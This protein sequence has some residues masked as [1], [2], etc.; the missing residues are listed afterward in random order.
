MEKENKKVL[1]AYSGGLDTS[2][3]LKWLLEKGYEVICFM[4]DVGQDEDFQQARDKALK[5][6]ASDCVVKDVKFHFV[7]NFVWPAIKM[8]LIYEKRYL[9]GTSLARPCITLALIETAKEHNCAYISHGATGKGNDQIRFE[10][11]AYALNPAIKVIAVWRLPEFCERFQGRNDLLEYAKENS[12]PV[13]ATLKKPW[14]MDANIMHISYESGILEDPSQSAPDDLYTMTKNPQHAPNNPTRIDI[15]FNH[16]IPVRCTNLTT[17]NTYEIPT[18]ILQYLNQIG[19][20]HG[21]GRVDLVENRFVG[22]KSRGIYETPG[23][24]ILYEAHLDLEVYCLDREIFRVKSFLADKMAEYVYNGF[25][26]SPEAEYVRKCLDESQRSVN[27]RV[28]IELFKG[29]VSIIGRESI[30]SLYN[31]ELV[32]MNVHG[33]LDYTAATGFIEINAIRL[34]EHYRAYGS[35]PNN[36]MH[37][38]NRKFSRVKLN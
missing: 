36:N 4:A 17:G 8:G 18:H 13:A 20:E 15:V 14:S 11:S 5:I 10:L 31:Q 23:C 2:C 27:G 16:G 35:T 25:W 21:I 3:I 6:G 34:K 1:L 24:K 33:Q 19:G 32:S 12:I 26:F 38:L 37:S 30:S 22:L 29:N 9:M 28:T 7:E